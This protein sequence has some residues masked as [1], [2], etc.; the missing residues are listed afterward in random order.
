MLINEDIKRSAKL[1]QKNHICL[2]KQCENLCKV[3]A[4]INNNKMYVDCDNQN[5][6]LY[7]HHMDDRTLCT[8][9]VRLE[10]FNK[11]KI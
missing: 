8:C 11:Y 7:K 6:C 9:P 10:I 1:C 5:G 2:S 3:I 4:V